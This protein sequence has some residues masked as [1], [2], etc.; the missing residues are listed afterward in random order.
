MKAV[1]ELAMKGRFN[2][3]VVAGIAAFIP[4][5]FWISAALVGLVTLRRGQFEGLK[6]LA[7]AYIGAI[8][9]AYFF[10]SLAMFTLVLWSSPFTLVL[11]LVLRSTSNWVWV[12]LANLVL[13]LLAAALVNLVF[14]E[15]I[16]SF[17]QTL[18]SELQALEQQTIFDQVILNVVEGNA[19]ATMMV[20]GISDMSVYVLLLARYWQAS[21]Y[22]PGG[23]RKEFHALRLPPWFI[24]LLGVV[25]VLVSFWSV[26]ALE[27]VFLP[28]FIA[29]IALVHG[30]VAK[31]DMGGPWLAAFY[32]GLLL[33]LQI[34]VPI[35][36]LIVIIDSWLDI[37]SRVPEPDDKIN[38]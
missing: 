5:T 12:F 3:L 2:A 28:L 31:R 14:A 26:W 20:A 25:G 10:G 9:G 7:G 11:A 34:L 22:N 27:P 4:I 29:G 33:L 23:F 1:A 8:A 38:S 30:L 21:L 36:L 19:L 32:M 6:I 15:Q 24:G 37:R 17:S 35:L 13:A 18:A 16:A